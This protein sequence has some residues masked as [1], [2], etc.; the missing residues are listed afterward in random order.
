MKNLLYV[1]GIAL[2]APLAAQAQ[3][4]APADQDKAAIRQAAYDYGEGFY[5][6]AAERMERAVHP[7]VLK[8]GLVAAP[9]GGAL[10]LA[11]M[12]AETLVEMTRAG[13]GKQP[14]DK[15]NISFELLDNREFVAT[16]RIFSAQFNDYLH[17]VKQDGRWR[18][19]EVLWQPPSPAGT[20]NGEADKAAVAQVI[21]DYVNGLAAADPA[22]IERLTHPEAALRVF[23][24]RPAPA[25][26]FLVENNRDAVVAAM[27]AKRAQPLPSPAVTVVDVYDNIASGVVTA[28]NGIVGYWH[29]AK[30]NGQW[31][32]VNVLLSV[33]PLG[34]TAR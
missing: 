23:P 24:L 20:A 27:R 32:V 29:L 10:M 18:I 4:P 13:S 19:A 12:N 34:M 16:A 21:K 15:R 17:L 8:R 25:R 5:E 22:P 2:V 31:R 11:P 3:T 1:L 7:A 28:S 6:G 14:P 26:S 30:Q 33:P 9:G